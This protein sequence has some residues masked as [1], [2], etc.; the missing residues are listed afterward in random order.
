M[1]DWHIGILLPLGFLIAIPISYGLFSLAWYFVHWNIINHE[2]RMLM[3][4]TLVLGFALVI[5]L[6]M[7]LDQTHV[8][9]KQTPIWDAG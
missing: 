6:V 1:K 2:F 9:K 3:D 5:V 8:E 7:T 4:R